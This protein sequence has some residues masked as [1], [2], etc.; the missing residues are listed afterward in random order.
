MNLTIP[1]GETSVNF[2]V[3]I[4]ND[5]L[6]EEGEVTFQGVIESVFPKAT[7]ILGAGRIGTTF[8]IVIEIPIFNDDG[9]YS[10]THYFRSAFNT[11]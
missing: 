9:N 3:E 7:E 5:T 8:R 1:A 4:L 6:A 10:C 11:S 2:S